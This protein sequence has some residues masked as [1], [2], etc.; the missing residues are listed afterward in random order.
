MVSAVSGG[1]GKLKQVWQSEAAG[2]VHPA[3]CGGRCRRALAL[4]TARLPRH[5][6]QRAA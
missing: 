5:L 6:D 4:A 3:A 2:I 1:V